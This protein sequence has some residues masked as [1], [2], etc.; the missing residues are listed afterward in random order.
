[1]YR[2][3]EKIKKNKPYFKWPNK[4]GSI[5]PSET[6]TY[7]GSI[8]KTEVIRLKVVGHCMIFGSVG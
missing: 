3:L 6:R 7:I 2:V 5:P 1:M 4:M 8:I